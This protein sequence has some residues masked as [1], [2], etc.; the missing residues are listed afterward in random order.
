MIM[1]IAT[2][3]IMIVKLVKT[4][5]VAIHNKLYIHDKILRIYRQFK[6]YQHLASY[7]ATM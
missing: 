3:L 4:Q 1:I 5:P 7:V 6:R 2:Y